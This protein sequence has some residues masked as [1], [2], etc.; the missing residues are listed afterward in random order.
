MIIYFTVKEYA[1]ANPEIEKLAAVMKEFAGAGAPGAIVSVRRGGKSLLRSGFGLASLESGLVNTPSTKMRIGSTTKHLACALAL[2]LRD[3]GKLSIDEPVSRWLP[4]LP[5]SQGRRT[6]RQ[7]MNHTGGTRDYLDLSL[8]SNGMAL[9][10]G[11]AAFD[12]QCRQQDDNFAAGAQFIYNNGGYRMLSMVIERVLD[13]PLAQA[14][15]E[16]LFEPLGMHDTSLW[17][18]DLDPLPGSAATHIA[19]PDGSF[20]KGIFPSVI[21]GEGGVASTL[22]DMQRWLAHLQAPTL[23]PAS[24]SME[25][26][27]PTELNNGHVT[28]YG[29]GLIRE[30]WRG[31]T[32]VHHAGGVVGGSCQMLAAPEHDIQIVV[33]TNRSDKAAPALAEQL[34]AALLDETLEAAATPADPALIDSYGGDYYCRASGRHYAIVLQDGV[35][36]LKDFGMPLPLQKGSGD[37]LHINLLSVIVLEV[38][39]LRDANGQVHA[40]DVTQQGRRMRCERVVAEDRAALTLA[41][42]AGNWVST[43]LGADIVIKS[44]PGS[45]RIAGLYGRNSYKL[46]P[47]LADVCLLS[48]DDPAVPLAGTLR[49]DGAAGEGRRLVL[50][51][52]RTRGLNLDQGRVHG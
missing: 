11:E 29:F 27:E 14:M 10:P 26:L 4:E 31:V 39:A 30:Q 38:T 33:I 42:F 37:T 2:L 9:A 18:S 8:L 28:R 23:W 24:L 44:E 45:M 12:Y 51:T 43:E 40:I 15:A 25:M 17:T 19:R 47:L 46:E 21:L 22:D 49:L 34:L 41:P 32:L 48:C 50:D 13:M 1:M 5:P 52:A 7:F 3:Q 36:C 35:L 6:L 16:H 20:G